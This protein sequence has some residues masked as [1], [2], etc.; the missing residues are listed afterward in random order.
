MNFN[1]KEIMN[2]VSQILGD[3]A[4][5][6]YIHEDIVNRDISYEDADLLSS[7]GENPWHIS[8]IEGYAVSYGMNKMCIYPTNKRVPWVIK[9]PITGIYA[10][11]SDLED[12]DE[13]EDDYDFDDDDFLAREAIQTG[14]A[15]QDFCDEEI[16]IYENCSSDVQGI[17]A[18]NYYVGHFNKIPI[19]IQEKVSSCH[20]T[21]NS[22][23]GS[24]YDYITNEINFLMDINSGIE[25]EDFVY[26]IVLNY[27]ITKAIEIFEELS[28]TVDDLHD[29]NYGYDRQGKAVIFDYA[30]YDSSYQYKFIA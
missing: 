7:I 20:A 28:S 8:E 12:S 16:A 5:G 21:I 3:N 15:Q 18:R 14:M 17:M 1:E 25:N 22:K 4:T 9:I 29:G 6:I 27:G 2:V 24:K 30:G 26:N 10:F 13:D 19:Y 11:K 23:Y